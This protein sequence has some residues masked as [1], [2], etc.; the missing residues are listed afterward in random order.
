M[1]ARVSEKQDAEENNL[2]GWDDPRN[3]HER[4]VG[5]PEPQSDVQHDQHDEGGDRRPAR[6][7]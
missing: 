1:A 6:F 3:A 7:P 2:E 4:L 5:Q